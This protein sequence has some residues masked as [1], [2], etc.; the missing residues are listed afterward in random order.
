LSFYYVKAHTPAIQ[1]P[2]SSQNHKTNLDFPI[3]L[4]IPS[5]GVNAFVQ[6]VG[7]TPTGDMDV[8]TNNIDVGWFD[9]GPRPGEPGS[10]VIAGH[11]DGKQGED[12]V[13]KNLYKLKAGDKI[14]TKDIQGITTT[15]VVIENRLYDPGSAGDVFS[16]QGSP[17]LNLITCDGVWDGIKKGFS[18]RL[19]VSADLIN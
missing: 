16:S 8:P 6:K 5:I 9:I 14:Y 3:R 1:F 13:F 10:S 12:G 17:R 7:V 15:F 4:S 18:K 2:I 11:F 19:V